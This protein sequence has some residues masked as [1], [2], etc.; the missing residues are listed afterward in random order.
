MCHVQLFMRL[1]QAQHQKRPDLSAL[2]SSHRAIGCFN[3]DQDR[4]SMGSSLNSLNIQF[5]L[6][7]PDHSS[8]MKVLAVRIL[9]GLHRHPIRFLIESGVAFA[10]GWSLIEPLQAMLAAPVQGT[11][12]FLALALMAVVVGIARVTPVNRMT[13]LIPGTTTRLTI[14]FQDLFE[15]EGV[16]A[17]PVNEFFDSVIGPHVSHLSI[18]GQVI[19]RFYNGNS[20]MFDKAVD[21]S[22]YSI[23]YEDV[24]RNS[25]RTRKFSLGTAAFLDTGRTSILAFVLAETDLLTLKARAD[26]PRLIGAL[27]GLWEAA[28]I[29][30]NDATLSVPLIG[31]GLSGICLSPQQLLSTIVMSAASVSRQ[32]RICTDI[33]IC[34]L[35][36]YRTDID[37]ESALSLII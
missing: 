24:H 37:I 30:C 31:G 8:T 12:R 27:D 32:N 14:A 35:S 11:S 1:K 7:L 2:I 21:L 16:I 18:H 28:R 13:A 15:A 20:D 3:F 23:P 17:V 29:H 25:G 36:K 10:A 22:L 34:L 9:I 19:K 5:L 4:S 6:H 26:V 33:H